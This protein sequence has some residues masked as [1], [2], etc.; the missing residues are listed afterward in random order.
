MSKEEKK[1]KVA[2]AMSGGVDSSVSAY[3]LKEQG[4]DAAGFF[5]RLWPGSKGNAKNIARALKVPFFEISAEKIFKKNVIDYFIEEYKNLRTPNPCIMCNKLIKF[6]WLLDAGAKKGFEKLST[7]HYC[8]IKK[9]KYGIYHLLKGK[10][11]AKDQS[12]FL[13]RLDQKQLARIIFPLG[14]MEKDETRRM[15]K[16]KKIP[17][18][19]Q[20]ESQE[21]CFLGN[22]DY[23]EFLRK[24]IGKKYFQQGNIINL[25]GKIIGRH[26]GLI[27]YTIGQR[28]GIEQLMV[29]NG[30]KK[31]LYVVG[32]KGKTNELV[33]GPDNDVYRKEMI[34][35]NLSWTSS[36]AKKQAFKN[37][38]LAVKIRYRHTA[39]SCAIKNKG[40]NK[41]LVNLRQSQRAITPGQSAVFYRGEEVLGGGIII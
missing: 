6:G 18:G 10:D 32:F 19:K 20:K 40:K 15:A 8:R 26:Q 16:L 9:D 12:Y 29:K 14:D 41:I 30:S 35:E 2:V 24:R 5:M 36:I 17:L 22:M 3:L 28:K 25:K 38:K 23:R 21:I 31:P 37:H 27:N 11:P 13:Y 1:L 33:V 4:Y 34:I 39:A 7:G